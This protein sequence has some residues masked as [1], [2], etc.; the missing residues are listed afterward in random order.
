MGKP[1][2]F[3]GGGEWLVISPLL[4]STKAQLHSRSMVARICLELW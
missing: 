4:C 1:V 2:C 3:W